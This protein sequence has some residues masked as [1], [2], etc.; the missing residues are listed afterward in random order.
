MLVS[1][2]GV[3]DW[4]GLFLGVSMGHCDRIRFSPFAVFVFGRWVF[5][6]G[7]CG[8]LGGLIMTFFLIFRCA[9]YIRNPSRH[10]ARWESCFLRF[11]SAGVSLGGALFSGGVFLLLCTSGLSVGLSF[12]FIF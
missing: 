2:W 1:R 3:L 6:V 10:F 9:S 5:S 4:F 8:G 11:S 7:I 12:G